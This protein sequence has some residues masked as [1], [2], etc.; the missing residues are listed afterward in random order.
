MSWLLLINHKASEKVLEIIKYKL[1]R[2]I[3]ALS[4]FKSNTSYEFAVHPP[5]SSVE[6]SADAPYV[7]I[8]CSTIGEL[9][10]VEPLLKKLLIDAKANLVFISEKKTYKDVFHNKYPEAYIAETQG[11]MHE[12]NLILKTLPLP[13]LFIVSEIPCLLHDAPCRLSY[14]F[15]HELKIKKVPIVVVNGWLYHEKPVC[16]IDRLEKYWF[17]RAYLR[18]VDNYLVQTEE[19]RDELFAAGVE[20]D[21]VSVAGNIKFDSVNKKEW[22]VESAKSKMT[23]QAIIEEH[24]PVITAGC[25]TNLSEQILVLNAFIRVKIDYP[26]VLLVMAPRH[27]ENHERMEI[28]EEYIIERNFRYAFKSRGG[29]LDVRTIDVLVLD[30]IGELK[31]FYSVSAFAYVGLNHNVLE[32]LA[33]GKRVYVTSGWNPIYPSYPVYSMLKQ[34]GAI[35]EADT[36]KLGEVWANELEGEASNLTQ[37]DTLSIIHEMQGATEK[38]YSVISKHLSI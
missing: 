1:F 14:A 28:L 7:W 13:D 8:Y 12:I 2:I 23:L 29:H 10:A 32:P 6:S 37:V 35:I 25:V 15:L 16:A 36:E 22:A 19:V 20:P 30:T 31:D 5:C 18:S 34:V 33:F 27:P 26:Q 24:R 21:R 3:E 38:C 11:A 9:N 17:D 4:S